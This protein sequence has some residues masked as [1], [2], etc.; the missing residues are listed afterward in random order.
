MVI[1]MAR[2]VMIPANARDAIAGWPAKSGGKVSPLTPERFISVPMAMAASHSTAQVHTTHF[3]TSFISSRS[4]NLSLF[5]RNRISFMR[6]SNASLMLSSFSKIRSRCYLLGPCA[7]GK[8]FH[9][10]GW[11][12]TLSEKRTPGGDHGGNA[13]PEYKP[14]LQ[15]KLGCAGFLAEPL[16]S[17]PDPGS[18]ADTEAPGHRGDGPDEFFCRFFFAKFFGAHAHPKLRAAGEVGGQIQMHGAQSRERL[19]KLELF[20][21]ARFAFGELCVEPALVV[22]RNGLDVLLRDHAFCS[23][24]QIVCT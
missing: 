5:L 13:P 22:G 6:S 8:S 9:L 17:A 7:C 12:N 15:Q 4:R 19:A 23:G 21:G 10:V 3:G 16:D 18:S 20:G 24:M 11:P 1:I 14:R 2:R